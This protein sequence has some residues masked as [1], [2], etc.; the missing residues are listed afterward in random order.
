MPSP[1]SENASG[2]E[3]LV[4]TVI[5]MRADFA[6]AVVCTEA[7]TIFEPESAVAG[8]LLEGP[9]GGFGDELPPHAP[10]ASAITATTA[11]PA[12]EARRD[13][14]VACP[15]PC[16]ESARHR[17]PWNSSDAL[18]AP[19]KGAPKILAEEGRT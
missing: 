12:T 16:L 9:T 18:G 14:K 8:A 1:V 19:L 11:M 10:S 6:A 7:S 5:D 2:P 17:K 4:E 3:P 13:V 15:P